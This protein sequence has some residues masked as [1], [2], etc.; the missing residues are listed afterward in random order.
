MRGNIL[1]TLFFAEDLMVG[2]GLV[3]RVDNGFFRMKIGFGDQVNGLALPVNLK[4][5]FG[6]V[7]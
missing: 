7:Q 1:Q 4:T 2:K 5:F 3:N 6:V